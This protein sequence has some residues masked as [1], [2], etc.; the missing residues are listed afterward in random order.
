MGNQ[1]G[2][3]ENDERIAEVFSWPLHGKE[4][5][6]AGATYCEVAAQGLGQRALGGL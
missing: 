6:K 5:R 4:E 2:K 1:G 3:A